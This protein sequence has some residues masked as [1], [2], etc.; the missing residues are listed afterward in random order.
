MVMKRPQRPCTPSR[1][2][3]AS[4]LALALQA[5]LTAVPAS[6]QALLSWEPPFTA[7]TPMLVEH[8]ATQPASKPWVLCVV[9]PHIKDAYWL[10][11]NYGMVE[12]A[13]RLRVEVRFFEAG[14][15]SQ[16]EVQRS[17]IQACAADA[18]IDALIVGAVSRQV[19]TAQLRRATARMP[20]IGTVNAIDGPGIAGKVGV[21]WEEMGRAAG[22]F[23]AEQAQGEGPPVPIA[24]FPGPRSVSE[25]VDRAFRQAVAGSRIVIRSTAW[26]DTGKAVQRNLLQ[27]VLDKHPDLR[28]VAGNALLAEAA[29]SV[30][31]ERGLQ[32]RIG[33]VSTYFT[34]AV[35][36]GIL[37]GRILAAPTDAPVLQGRLSIGLAVDLLEQR[38]TR[39]HFGP[40]VRTLDRDNLEQIEIGDSL[41]PPLLMPQFHYRPQDQD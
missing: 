24:W 21:D 3:S 5:P 16:L 22:A 14:G 1:L 32:D 38:P 20:V 17:Q 35:Q 23:L 13:R 7:T 36:R 19:M 39:R 25:G 27:Q 37:R 26:G 4:L 34:P 6:A 29:I 10:G 33:V 9:V 11:V 40:V 31:R 18:R 30:L 12:E 41:P 8:V 15:Y 28:Y 2:T